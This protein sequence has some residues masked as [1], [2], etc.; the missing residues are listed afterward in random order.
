ML[1][2]REGDIEEAQVFGDLF[3]TGIGTVGVQWG[4]P[5]SSTA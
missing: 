5:R 1:G 4:D 3:T 2:A